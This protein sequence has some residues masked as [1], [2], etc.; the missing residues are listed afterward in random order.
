MIKNR[1]GTE[2]NV[3][4]SK[5]VSNN[6]LCTATDKRVSK[7]APKRRRNE[8]RHIPL[9]VYSPRYIRGAESEKSPKMIPRI[10]IFTY[11]Y[12]NAERNGRKERSYG[13]NEQRAAD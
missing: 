11:P 8:D 1:Y 13:T 12:R 7:T 3:P 4:P 6:P 10:Y 9:S 5:T 2:Q